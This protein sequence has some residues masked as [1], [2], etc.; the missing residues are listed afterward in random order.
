MPCE[1]PYPAKRPSPAGFVPASSAVPGF[2]RASVE[3]VQKAAQ[4]GMPLLVAVSAPTALAVRTAREAGMGLVGL[5][6]GDDL[7]IY[8]G[9]QLIELPTP[10]A[11]TSSLLSL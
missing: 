9:E 7:V 11:S 2:V 4:A 3:M 10:T 5:A 8:C 6:R 1:R